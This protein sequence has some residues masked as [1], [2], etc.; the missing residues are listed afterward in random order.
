MESRNVTPDIS[1]LIVNYNAGRD[2]GRTLQGLAA[3]TFRDFEALVLDNAS[4]DDSAAAAQALVADDAR[5]RFTHLRRNV[6]FAAGNNLMAETA[7]GTWLA[8]LNPD[9]VPAPDWLERLLEATGRHPA[10]VM[11]GSTQL[12]AADPQRLDGAGDHYLAIGLPWRGGHGWPLA[13]LPPE[14]EVFSPCAAACLIRADAFRDAHGFD[15]R[16]F[17]YV[18]DVDLGFRL[19]LQGHHCIQVPAAVVSHVGGASSA[20]QSS[21]FAR[22]HGTR[23][24][25]WCFVKCMPAGLFWPLLPLHLL[26]L[27]FLMLRAAA[28]GMGY[29]VGAGI[30][31][32]FAGMPAIWSARSALQRGRRVGWRRIAAALTWNPLIYLRR[33]PQIL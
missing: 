24:L 3:Q 4:S 5:F 8:L 15:E 23:N 17:C 33:A 9:A 11:F 21:G 16:F 13:A 1:V 26:A 29:P 12:D 2:L 7:R 31:E 19:R 14:G 6:G 25:M 30:I 10:A 18:E 32:G 28:T 27:A 22:R 20:S